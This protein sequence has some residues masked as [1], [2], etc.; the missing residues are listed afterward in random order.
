MSRRP[1]RFTQAD[2]ARALRAIEQTGAPV[3]IVIGE[4]GEIR[5]EPFRAEPKGK[6]RRF[7]AEPEIVL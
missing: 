7:V 1:A 6:K 2:I 4:D 3:A 5:L